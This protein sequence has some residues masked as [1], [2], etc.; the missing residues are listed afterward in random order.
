PQH[1]S[2][3]LTPNHPTGIADGIAVFDALKSRRKD[4]AIFA[5][6]DALRVSA[7]FRDLIIPVE[8]REGEKAYGKSRVMLEATARAFSDDRSIVLFPSGRI[9]YWNQGRLTERPWQTSATVLARRYN[10]PIVP[11]HIQARNSG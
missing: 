2:F 3:I 11:A 6:S 1:G 8:W 4:M 10:V 7:G 5:N 9:A